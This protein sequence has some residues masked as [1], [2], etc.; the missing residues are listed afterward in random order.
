MVIKQV[1]SFLDFITVECKQNPFTEVETG[2]SGEILPTLP[3]VNR[4]TKREADEM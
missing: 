3:P 1:K 4:N 2:L